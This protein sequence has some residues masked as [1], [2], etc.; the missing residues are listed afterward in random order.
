LALRP[1]LECPVEYVG[2]VEKVK[3]TIISFG[4]RGDVQPIVALGRA[5]QARGHQVRMITG[6]NFRT[7]VDEHGLE[8]V[9]AS[10][11]IQTLMMGEGGREWIEQGHNPIRQMRI[12]KKLFDQHGLAIMRDAWGACEDAEVVVSSFTSDVFAASIAEKLQAK[13]ISTPLQPALVATRSGAATSQAP[14]PHRASLVNYFFGR[15]LI[16]PFG[17]RLMGSINNRFREETLRLPRQSYRQNRRRLRRMLVVQGFS[18]HVVQHP[19]DW[20]ANIHTTGYWFLDEDREWQPPKG[21]LDFLDAGD[22]PV[23]VGFG[24]MT[25]RNPDA[26]TRIILNAVAQSGQRAILQSG[27]AGIGDTQLP[28][29]IFLLDAAPHGWLFPHMRAVVHHGGAGTT[30]ESLRAGVPTVI[31][32]HIADQPFWGSRVAALGVGPQPIPRKKLTVENLASAILRASGDSVMR[33]RAARLGAKIRAEDGISR[34]MGVIEEYLR[35]RD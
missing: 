27:W 26:L 35:R 17:W 18:N 8:A 7:W 19:S 24:S 33:E 22:P 31:V 6:G 10:V 9:A 28:P 2:K 13:H 30:A 4:T 34:A 23:Y 3:I 14:L 32:P 21:L 29:N 15:W 25:G 20:P 1:E 12:M 11:D 5:L 16:E